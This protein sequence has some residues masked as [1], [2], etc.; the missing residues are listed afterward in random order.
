[1]PGNALAG[2]LTDSSL[3]AADERPGDLLLSGRGLGDDATFVDRAGTAAYQ[4]GAADYAG[5][6]F[7]IG[8]DG[9]R[10][11]QSHLAGVDFNY[12]LRGNSKYYARKSG[13]TGVHEATPGSIGGT[14]ALSGYPT[15]INGLQ[16]SFRDSNM[17]RSLVAGNFD[18]KAPTNLKLDFENLKFTCTGAMES[19]TLLDSNGRKPLDYWHAELTPLT[20]DSS[21]VRPIRVI[22]RS[23]TRS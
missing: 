11:G 3:L 23:A 4:A 6:N 20:L 8:T 15:T 14:F 21:A 12:P 7:R 13:V 17:D 10:Q 22:R 18:F 1:M 19:V 9:A 5:M 2:A 16:F